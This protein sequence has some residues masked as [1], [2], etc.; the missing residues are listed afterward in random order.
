MELY[1][2]PTGPNTPILKNPDKSQPL[3]DGVQFDLV[4]HKVK[5]GGPSTN[6]VRIYI[7]TGCGP[8][9]SLGAFLSVDSD[10]KGNTR[11]YKF[12][13]NQPDDDLSYAKRFLDGVCE[14][15]TTSGTAN[16]QYQDEDSCEHLSTIYVN[17]NQP[18]T[19]TLD[20]I[21]HAKDAWPCTNGECVLLIRPVP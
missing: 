4:G 16:D 21:S 2:D 19:P 6:G 3:N 1:Q 10:G 8:T 18:P 9:N 7:K 15:P 17:I 12:R 14:K 11:F 20:Y 13:Q 5:V